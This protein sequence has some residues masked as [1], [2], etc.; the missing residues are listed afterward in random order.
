MLRT[1]VAALQDE[2]AA[3]SNV[4]AGPNQHGTA[5]AATLPAPKPG[6]SGMGTAT[7]LENWAA[8]HPLPPVATGCGVVLLLQQHTCC[9]CKDDNARSTCIGRRASLG[10]GLVTVRT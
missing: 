8:L 10:V 4:T 5:A 2:V 1:E 7:E 3:I 9:T 6:R